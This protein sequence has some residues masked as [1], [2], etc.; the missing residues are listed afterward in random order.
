MINSLPGR[1]HVP[2]MPV[3]VQGF[4]G[5]QRAVHAA[6]RHARRQGRRDAQVRFTIYLRLRALSDPQTHRSQLL[7]L[8]GVSSRLGPG[9]G[10][11]RFGGSPRLVGRYCTAQAGWWNIPNLSQPN[12][13]PRRD[14]TPCK[15]KLNKSPCLFRF[16]SQKTNILEL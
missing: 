12:P 13:G 4:H 10:L 5:G 3:A 9:L 16:F 1:P 7:K 6:R 8:Q 15:G 2:D 11:L 14:E